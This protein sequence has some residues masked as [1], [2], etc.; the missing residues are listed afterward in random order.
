MTFSLHQ[1]ESIAA[2]YAAKQQIQLGERLGFGMDGAVWKSSRNSAIKVIERNETYLRERD[3]YRRL[4]EDEVAVLA[5]F[6][7]PYL[8]DY[9]NILQ[10][11]EMS[12]VAPP[13]VLDFGKAYLDQPPDF[14]DDALVDLWADR[15]ELY[16]PHQWPLVRK[17]LAALRGHGIHYFDP[18]PGNIRFPPEKQA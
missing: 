8:I 3:C 5:G 7:V 13:C 18:Q 16:E 2:Q 11:V 1:A 14:S 9:D 10:V 12:I 15:E 6:V 17:V 4:L